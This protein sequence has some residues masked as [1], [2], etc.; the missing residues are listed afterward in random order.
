MEVAA[1]DFITTKEVAQILRKSE[2]WVKMLRRDG[3]GPPYYRL[4]RGIIY[5][6]SELDEWIGLAQVKD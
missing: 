1:D 5:K 6:R 4:G 2:W 3:G